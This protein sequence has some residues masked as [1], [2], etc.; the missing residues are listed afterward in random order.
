M[1]KYFYLD[2]TRDRIHIYVIMYL[3]IILPLHSFSK[4]GIEKDK[5]VC[6]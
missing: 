6:T 1:Y 5:L 3:L 4:P 2:A